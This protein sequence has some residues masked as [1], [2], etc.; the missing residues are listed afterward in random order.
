MIKQRIKSVVSPKQ[1]EIATL[2]CTASTDLFSE[3]ELK[4]AAIESRLHKRNVS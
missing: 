4:R 2:L 1:R 3:I